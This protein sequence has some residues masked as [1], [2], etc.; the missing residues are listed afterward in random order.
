MWGLRGAKRTQMN[1]LNIP[2]DI[3]IITKTGFVWDFSSFLLSFRE[4][5]VLRLRTIKV[6]CPG[7]SFRKFISPQTGSTMLVVSLNLVISEAVKQASLNILR[8]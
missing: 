2:D 5:R 7:N 3:M 4:A 6:N 1:K 8:L